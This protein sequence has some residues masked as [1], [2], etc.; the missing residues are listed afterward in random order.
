ME[1]NSG[2]CFLHKVASI[3]GIHIHFAH[4]YTLMV[5]K[6]W[7][8]YITSLKLDT[9]HIVEIALW[10]IMLAL[11]TSTYNQSALLISSENY[12]FLVFG[13]DQIYL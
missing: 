1:Q 13:K 3:V 2:T 8:M 12:S 6:E 7:I 10:D 4:H 11:A 9:K 5:F